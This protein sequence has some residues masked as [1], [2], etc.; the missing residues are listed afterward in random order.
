MQGTSPFL[1]VFDD[2]YVTIQ[3]MNKLIILAAV[4]LTQTA[5]AVYTVTSGVAYLTT[6]K[7]IP[8]HASSKLT[9][10]DCDAVRMITRLTYYCE[11]NDPSKTYNRNGL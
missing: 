1:L 6:S 7:S 10:S 8:D 9:Y 4:C 11:Q 2:F 5:C 3:D